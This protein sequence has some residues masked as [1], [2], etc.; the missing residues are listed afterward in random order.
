[1]YW[2]I[3]RMTKREPEPS[4]TDAPRFVLHRHEDASGVHHDLR[5]E[6]GNCLLGFASAT[7][8][9]RLLGNSD[10]PPENLAGRGSGYRI[11]TGTYRLQDTAADCRD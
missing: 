8:W 10:A 6:N 1:M 11:Q 9:A 4:E 2:Q 3:T 5:L 7:Q